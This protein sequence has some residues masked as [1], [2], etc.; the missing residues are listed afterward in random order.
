MLRQTYSLQYTGLYPLF[1]AGLEAR[2]FAISFLMTCFFV[3]HSAWVSRDFMFF[4]ENC[5]KNINAFFLRL[6]CFYL[7]REHQPRISDLKLKLGQ[8]I[9]PE[10]CDCRLRQHNKNN[11]KNNANGC[12]RICTQYNQNQWQKLLLRKFR[13]FDSQLCSYKSCRHT[14]IIAIITASCGATL[15]I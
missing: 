7:S 3:R 6:L 15:Y 4:P 11:K 1:I 13:C 10:Y 14:H 12:T 2:L 8:E 5:E 9:L